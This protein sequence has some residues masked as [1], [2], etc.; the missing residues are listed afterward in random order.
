MSMLL[1]TVEKISL[2]GRR[3]I[4]CLRRL[5]CQDMYTDGGGA[6]KFDVGAYLDKLQVLG[7]KYGSIFRALDPA[8]RLS[9]S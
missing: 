5:Y 1:F 6:A 3:P 9:V 2:L 8:S 4:F 7:T